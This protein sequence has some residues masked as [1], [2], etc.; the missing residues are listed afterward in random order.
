[1]RFWCWPMLT[2]VAAGTEAQLGGNALSLVK[3]GETSRGRRSQSGSVK[4]LIGVSMKAFRDKMK[5]ESGRRRE[6]CGAII[7]CSTIEGS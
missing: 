7:D 2:K 5:A 6:E 1:M 4:G 3:S